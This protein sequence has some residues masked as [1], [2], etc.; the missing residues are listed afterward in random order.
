MSDVNVGGRP[1]DY[2]DELADLICARL[3]AGESM[4]SVSRDDAMPCMTT[5]F[6]WLR[7]NP[8]FAQQYAK[9]KEE[10]A[11]ALFEQIL[12]IADDGSNDWVE[13]HSEDAG[14][15]AYKVNGEAIQRSKL[16]V[17]TRKWMAGK[18][19]PK[20]YGDQVNTNITP[21]K[22]LSIEIVRAKKPDANSTD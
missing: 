1:T 22:P 15:A 2:N 8:Q 10:S 6:R 4:R 20:K 18:M 14:K 19:R 21:D 3:S 11:D 16:R 17:D 12:D 7:V 13:Q 9:A 5:L